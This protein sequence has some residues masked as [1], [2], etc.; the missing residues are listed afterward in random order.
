MKISKLIPLIA[1]L[2]LFNSSSFATENKDCESL[3]KA[4]TGA[5]VIES[6]K[7]RTQRSKDGDSI[8]TKIKNIFIKKN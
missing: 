7:C 4:K 1:I 8:G 3:L 2:T 5:K 6:W